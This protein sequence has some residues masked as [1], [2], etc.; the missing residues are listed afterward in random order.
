MRKNNKGD[1]E[2]YFPDTKKTFAHSTVATSD[3]I[4]TLSEQ[5]IK[6][7]DVYNAIDYD[8]EAK[9]IIKKFIDNGFSNFVFRDFVHR[10]PERIFRKIEQGKIL[11]IQAKDLNKHL[12]KS[13]EDYDYDF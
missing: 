12:D 5:Y 8:P 9:E 4:V 3:L 13:L 11:H 10:N 1:V 7:T 2:W 6:T